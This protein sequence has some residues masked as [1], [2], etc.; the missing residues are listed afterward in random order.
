MHFQSLTRSYKLDNGIQLSV[1]ADAFNKYFLS[2]PHNI[3]A[4]V[5]SSVLAC[6]YLEKFLE[7]SRVDVEIVS[8]IVANLDARKVTGA[9]S[10]PLSLLKLFL[11]W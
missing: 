4:I 8:S 11:L 10:T 2:I 5:I 3:I 9:D 6:K 1:T 7:F